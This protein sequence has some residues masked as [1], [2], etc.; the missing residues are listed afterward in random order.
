MLTLKKKVKE[1]AWKENFTKTYV[2]IQKLI[3]ALNKL[4]IVTWNIAK[5]ILDLT[6]M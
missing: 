1:S 3:T 4:L 6:Y 2:F 5:F